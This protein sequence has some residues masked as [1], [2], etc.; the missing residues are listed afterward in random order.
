MR[1]KVNVND[2][3]FLA[4]YLEFQGKGLSFT[5]LSVELKLAPLS[6][7]QRMNKLS[8]SLSAKGVEIPRMPMKAK[9]KANIDVLVNIVNSYAKNTV[10]DVED[11]VV[12]VKK[13]NSS[14]MEYV[15]A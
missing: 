11:P 13:K 9:Q 8:K 3:T 1:T 5:D 4:K 14:E 15:D 2:E 7:Y 12:V 10:K 6:L